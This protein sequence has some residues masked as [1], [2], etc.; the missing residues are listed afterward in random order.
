MREIKFRSIIPSVENPKEFY[1][2]K[3]DV[4]ET[5]CSIAYLSSFVINSYVRSL[6]ILEMEKSILNGVFSEV[7]MKKEFALEISNCFNA[8]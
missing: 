5:I 3:K 4:H 1:L 8:G 6:P 7:F 2:D